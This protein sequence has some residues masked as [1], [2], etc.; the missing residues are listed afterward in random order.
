MFIQEN[1][2][3]PYSI[4]ATIII[5]VIIATE[6][7]Q[8]ETIALIIIALLHYCARQSGA[9]AA[10]SATYQ[11]ATACMTQNQINN[12]RRGQILKSYSLLSDAT[13]YVG[14][15]YIYYVRVPPFA[16]LYPV[17]RIQNVLMRIRIPLFML[18][19][20]RIRFVQLGRGKQIF[21]NSFYFVFQTLTTLVMCNFLSNNAGGGVRDKV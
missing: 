5:T 7:V 18:I 4:S 8:K 16:S 11:C 21:V 9:S 17:W 20:I 3:D 2:V 13:K 10:S 19:Q 6:T 14:N 1:G 12:V 15:S